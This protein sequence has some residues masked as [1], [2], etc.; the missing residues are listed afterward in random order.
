MILP[1]LLLATA[2]LDGLQGT[3]RGPGTVLNRP[4]VMEQTF[5][6]ALL[7]RFTEQRMR[8]LASD[9]ASRASFEGRAFYRPVGAS[10]PD[11]VSGSWL[12]ARGV[13]FAL[14]ASCTGDVLSSQWLGSTER[15]RTVYAR[16]A[17]TLV[18]IDSV[19][20]ATAPARE[21]GRS[22]L[23]RVPR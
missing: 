12:D 9:T 16:I 15:G 4:I 1:T 3:W 22:R 21:F 2:C 13:S 5:A 20:P 14:A 6:P 10:Q 8:H 18:V 19:Y 17:D 7:G 11:S 23:V